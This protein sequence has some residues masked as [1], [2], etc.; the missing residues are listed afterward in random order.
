MRQAAGGRSAAPIPLAGRRGTSGCGGL[1][2]LRLL[3]REPHGP[4][5]A[6]HI[7]LRPGA[8]H[9]GGVD[10]IPPA[11][12]KPIAKLTNPNKKKHFTAK[13]APRHF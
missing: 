3:A 6:A 10:Q 7:R 13:S 4:P 2:P 11:A 8:Q 12:L 1:L 9:P 5:A